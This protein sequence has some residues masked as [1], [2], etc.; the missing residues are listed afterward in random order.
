MKQPLVMKP[1][2]AHDRKFFSCEMKKLATSDVVTL[3]A[4]VH[5]K[6]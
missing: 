4:I 6:S 2:G 3:D 5:D 1:F